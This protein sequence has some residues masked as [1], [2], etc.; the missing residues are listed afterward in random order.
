MN[1]NSIVIDF[2]NMGGPVHSGRSKG[3]LT[4]KRFNLD[5]IDRKKCKVIVR[6]PETTYSVTSSFFLGLFGES[7]RQAGSRKDFFSRYEFQNPD[8]F[9]DTFETCISRALQ[10]HRALVHKDSK[11]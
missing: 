3:E 6:I 10:E 11:S 9:C 4:R 8:V 7:I 1:T 2:Q 5:A